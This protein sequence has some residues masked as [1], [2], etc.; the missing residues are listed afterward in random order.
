MP[1]LMLKIFLLTVLMVCS[2]ANAETEGR[3]KFGPYEVSVSTFN[4]LFVGADVAKVHN[5]VRAKDQTLINVSVIDERTGTTVAAEV[6]ATAKN[7]LQQLKTI[8]FK[9]IEEP[10][11]VYYIGS[12]RHSNR[13]I[14]HFNFDVKVD[15]EPN[16]FTFKM[17]KKLYTE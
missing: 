6:T 8:T 14:F 9:K 17:T 11:A 15:G 3:K 4:S 1:H 10:G 16:A 13:E 7:L 2:A 12:L 5:L